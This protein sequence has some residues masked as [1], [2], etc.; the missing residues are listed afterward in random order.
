[1]S[2]QAIPPESSLGNRKTPLL[3][4]WHG[5]SGFFWRF[6]AWLQDEAA[7]RLP[8]DRI[9][10]NSVSWA[11]AGH[12]T[13]IGCWKRKNTSI[14]RLPQFSSLEQLLAFFR[15]APRR[16]C[17]ALTSGPNY[18]KLGNPVSLQAIPPESSLGNGK[19][20]LLTDW[21]GFGAFSAG[22]KTMLPFAYP[23]TEL[24][25]TRFL[26]L[27]QAISPELGVGSGKI[28]VLAD[29]PNFAPWSNFWRFFGRL[30]DDAVLRL[31]LDRITPNSVSCVFAGHS[32]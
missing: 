30:Q 21:H 28:P 23:W 15:P 9:A 14:S 25:Q 3:A 19:T 26:G 29:Y 32:T 27:L 20:P 1:M 8:L 7:L 11:F 24:H 31:P 22:S 18:T 4:D 2:L 5:F 12:F 10:P 17:P 13:R 6:F 16:R